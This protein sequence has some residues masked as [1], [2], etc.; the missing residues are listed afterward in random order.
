MF[1]TVIN[2]DDLKRNILAITEP[3]VKLI[4]TFTDSNIDLFTENDPVVNNDF[5]DQIK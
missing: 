5:L 2:N 1:D 3:L 4:Y